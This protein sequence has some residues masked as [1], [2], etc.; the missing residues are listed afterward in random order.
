M[1]FRIKVTLSIL[2]TLLILA[3]VGPLLVP[4]SP[5]PDTQSETSLAQPGSAFAE[6]GQLDIHYLRVDDSSADA[7]QLQQP[8]VLLHGYLFNTQTWRHV[9]PSLAQTGEVISFDRTGFGLTTRP[10]AGSWDSELSPYS[11]EAHARQTLQ[12]LDELEIEQAVLVGHNSG[13][14]VA[15]EVALLAPSRVSGLVLTGPAVYRV[16]GPP[17]WLRPILGTPHMSRLGPLLMRQLAGDAGGGFVAA[18][19]ADTSQIDEAALQAYRQNF[20]VH[21]WDRALWEVS[22]ASH[23]V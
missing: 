6:V 11:P 13:A 23:E 17:G 3:L 22:K 4:V 2:L 15:L 18:N 8:V 1:P 21:D 10:A 7:P 9:Q 20:L 12:L 19:W 5:L 14:A 16:G